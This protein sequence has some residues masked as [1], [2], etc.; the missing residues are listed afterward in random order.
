MPRPVRP[1]IRGV[2]SVVAVVL[3]SSIVLLAGGGWAEAAV[4]PPPAHAARV[5][6]KVRPDTAP[7]AGIAAE[8][9]ESAAGFEADRAGW[10]EFRARY[11]TDWSVWVD[12]RSGSPTLV[13]GRGIALFGVGERTAGIDG[14]DDLAA[15]VSAFLATHEALFR[16]GSTE[17]I[18]DRAASAALDPRRAVLVW[19]RAVHG[20]PVEDERFIAYVHDGRLVAFGADRW[21][22]VDAA[23]D[24]ALGADAARAALLGYLETGPADV[25]EV[26]PARLVFAAAPAPQTAGRYT[27]AVG[28]GLAFRLVWRFTLRLADVNGTYVARVDAQTGEVVHF[29][30]DARYG[31]ARGGVFPVSDDGVGYD[32][33]EQPGWP[34]PF[35][36]VTIDGTAQVANDMGLFACTPAGGTATSALA[37]AYV[38]VSDT[39]GA[40]AQ[41]ATCE[42]DLDF[43]QGAGTDCAVPAGASAGNTH[44]AR[45]SFYHLNRSMEKGRAWLPGNTWLQSQMVDHVNINSTCNAYWDGASVNFYKS[46]GGCRNTGEIAGVFVHEWGHGLDDNDGGGYDNPSE[47][48]ADIVAFLDTHVSCVGRGFYMAQNCGGYGNACLGC[49][50]IRDQDWN[51]RANHVPSTPQGF[52]ASYCGG[53]GGPCGKEVHCEGYVSAEA[54]WDLAN[55]DLPAMGLD[56][57]TAWQLTDKLFFKS[58]QGSGGNAYNCALPSSDGC[59]AGSWFTKFRT[60]DD[61]DGNLANG[62]PH[63]AA[64]YAAFA[65]HN[66]ACGGASDA[67]NQNA[68]SCGTLAAPALGA[69]ASPNSATLTW[70]AVAGA[71][72]YLVLRN[73]QS[74]DAGSTIVATVPAPATSWVDTDLPNG[75]PVHYRVQAQGANAA[76]ESTL[77]NCQ[78]VA[79]QPYAG[80]IRLDRP[81]YGC[82]VTIN[83][84]VLDGNVGA[85]TT[86]ATLASTTEP[87][88][89]TIV[90][91]ATAPGSATFVAALPTS[92][93]P[94]AHGDGLLSV[95]PGD[96]ITAVYVD[97]DD[98]AG[99]HDLVRQATATVDCTVPVISAV[100]SGG[101]TDTSATITWTSDKATDTRVRYG[102]VAPP[103]ALF[104]KPEAVTA[105]SAPL[106]GL[107]GCTRYLYAVEGQDVAGNL[108]SSDNGGAYYAFETQGNFGFG[109]QN[110]HDGKLKLL[111]PTVSCAGTL[112][113]QVGDVDLNRAID[114]VD[115]L[116]VTVSSATEF[117]AETVVLTETGPN[118]S[119]FTGGVPVTTAAPVHGDG[120]LSVTAGDYVTA[121][122]RDA[123][124]AAGNAALSYQSG[125]VDCTAAQASGLTV[126]S[127]TDAAATVKWS[128]AETTLGKVEWGPTPALG[129]VVSDAS[130]RAAHSLVL[131]PLSSCGK[132]YFRVSQTDA[133]GNTSVTD[134]NG[135]PF[136]FSAYVVPNLAFEDNFETN[137]GWT[138]EGEWQI[139]APHGLGTPPGDPKTPYDGA[140]VLG[141]DLTGLG[142][143]KGDYEPGTTQRAISPVINAVGLTNLHLYFENWLRAA[144]G[145]AATI[146]VQKNG[147]WHT[148]WNSDAALGWS[149]T[150]WFQFDVNISQYADNNPSLRIAFKQNGGAATL[151]TQGGWNVDQLFI[152]DSTVPAYDVCGGCGN[153]PSF[154]GLRS[155]RDAN[156]CAAGSIT[157]TWTEAP[158]WGTGRKGSYAVYRDTVPNF[159]PS[160]ANLVAKGITALTYN[161]TTAPPET[162]VWYLVRAEDNETCGGGPNNGGVVDGNTVYVAARDATGQLPP[163]SVGASLRGL[164]SN[165]VQVHL[166]WGAAANAATYHVNR[167]TAATGPFS[168]TGDVA[169]LS[170]D[171]RDQGTSSIT[172]FY[173]VRAADR[174]GTEGP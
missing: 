97:A 69:A 170:Y 82:A 85:S 122:Y 148:V 13:E 112:Q 117:D 55:R 60:V 106:T 137:K 149:S 6:G 49:T 123:Q 115:T 118:T 88:P 68:S 33:T 30:D 169:G 47:A 39:C 109:L 36:D 150:I 94:A 141:H 17:L 105:H 113:V 11:G 129:N 64:I 58:R 3:L 46:G 28:G 172:Y 48:Y 100:A 103:G 162:D 142:A 135:A 134:A 76:C 32:G 71:A 79:P 161:D 61:D 92:S 18:L 110:C 104:V 66:I 72:N 23:T 116:R 164:L 14:I 157:L 80:T 40:I 126:T 78:V 119:V 53:G 140:R 44:A 62:T 4:V 167:A 132:Y 19:T 15:R 151:Q 43:A 8:R 166:S 26:E 42:A 77:S 111:T 131:Q 74:C 27:G 57:P 171:D 153:A 99:G 73:D 45:S 163:G 146:E 9:P 121:T 67:S 20:V 75:F 38:K 174:C 29:F 16:V 158:A 143:H 145:A 138:L 125:S 83:A 124:N 10:A 98:G 90:L 136:Q 101:V 127:L 56:A 25:V 54:V 86:T 96:V 41:T 1:A 63:A 159:T 52:L 5:A 102:P 7:A 108:A 59:G 173:D 160:A 81:A 84:S 152:Q 133:L 31:Q 70:T 114:V 87:T 168:K 34:L 89:E 37:G 51:M 22:A 156:A 95:Q 24:P 147:V 144:W 50:G 154:A 165:A 130:S 21:G 12:R 120:R 2:A 107:A 128:T 91:T 155:A 65:R 139:D 93:A 35:A